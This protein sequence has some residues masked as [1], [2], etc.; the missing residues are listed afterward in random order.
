MDNIEEFKKEI[1]KL[2]QRIVILEQKR[3]Y[4]ADLIPQAVKN[5]NMGEPNSYVFSGLAANRPT[6]GTKLTST[7]FGCS[8]YWATDTGVLSIWSGTAWLSETFT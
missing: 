2:K 3:I 5:R 4:Q 8:I 1:E 6:T 7:G